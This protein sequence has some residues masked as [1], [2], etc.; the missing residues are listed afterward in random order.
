MGEEATKLLED[1][2]FRKN[3]DEGSA[4]YHK[5]GEYNVVFFHRMLSSAF[6]NKYLRYTPAD[7]AFVELC[8]I[9]TLHGSDIDALPDHASI[10]QDAFATASANIG[11]QEAMKAPETAGGHAKRARF[12]IRQPVDTTGDGKEQSSSSDG[13]ED[14]ED[15]KDDRKPPGGRMGRDEED[16]GSVASDADEEEAKG[17]T[18]EVAGDEHDPLDTD[19]G[20]GS[21]KRG[22]DATAEPPA[23]A[24]KAK[25]TTTPPPVARTPVARAAAK[26]ASTVTAKQVSPAKQP[27]ATK[28]ADKALHGGAAASHRR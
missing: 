1:K 22:G 12:T 27:R 13:E 21:R 4:T 8:V 26:E 25:R 11:P 16:D 23:A 28:A 14:A 24:K 9:A 15:A 3:S 17:P 7:I 6:P 5:G 18:A 2:A 20:D 10:Y 19:D